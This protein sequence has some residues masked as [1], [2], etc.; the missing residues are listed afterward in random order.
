MARI[1]IVGTKTDW[2]VIRGW[3]NSMFV[4]IYSAISGL[5]ALAYK[6]KADYNN[7]I[8]N[9][10]TLLET[11]GVDGSIQLKAA[12]GSL[13]SVSNVTINDDGF[14]YINKITLTNTSSIFEDTNSENELTFEDAKT[15]LSYKI[16]E[17]INDPNTVIDSDY[18]HTDNNFTDTLKN[19]LDGIEDGAQVNDANTTLQGN[20]FNGANQLVQLDGDG[21]LPAIDGSQL[22]NLP[23]GGGGS[24]IDQHIKFEY[25][26]PYEF[27]FYENIRITTL[28]GVGCTPTL[29]YKANGTAY[30]LNDTISLGTTMSLTVNQ[31]GGVLMKGEKV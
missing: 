24:S 1:P 28:T 27:T 12:D 13:K 20:T 4:E 7:D 10:P 2:S 18:V 25:V 23:S 31:L 22:T 17:L 11:A 9:L 29:V 26:T 19:K 30:V 8:D 5:G 6:D 16:S 3:L 21:K 15:G 14:L